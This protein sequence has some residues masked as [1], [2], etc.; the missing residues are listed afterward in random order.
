M[1]ISKIDINKIKK[2]NVKPYPY[3]HRDIRDI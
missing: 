2:V 3:K 1:T